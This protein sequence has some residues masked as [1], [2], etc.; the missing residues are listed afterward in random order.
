MPEANETEY[1]KS[2]AN[3]WEMGCVKDPRKNQ[4]PELRIPPH[5]FVEIFKS[6]Q[7][8]FP[9][10]KDDG[11]TGEFVGYIMPPTKGDSDKEEPCSFN[12]KL[13]KDQSGTM[14]ATAVREVLNKNRNKADKLTY[15]GVPLLA[16]AY[17][18][19][20]MFLTDEKN[21]GEFYFLSFGFEKYRT[22]DGLVFRQGLAVTGEAY[23]RATLV[24]QNFLLFEHSLREADLSLVPG[25]LKVPSNEICI[26]VEDTME[27]V[28]SYPEVR[29]FLDAMKDEMTNRKKDMYILREDNILSLETLNLSQE[30]RLRVLL[31]LKSKASAEYKHYHKAS[32]TYSHYAKNV[33]M[34]IETVEK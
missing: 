2:I 13:E 33:L 18:A 20:I 11:N 6:V 21:S 28:D 23:N 14:R 17:K 29:R 30:E 8:K 3:N 16:K 32:G 25:L 19:V 4:N 24:S 10:L 31:L 27:L 1:F 15:T 9:V 26:S 34:S 5:P 7:S 22:Q 12:L